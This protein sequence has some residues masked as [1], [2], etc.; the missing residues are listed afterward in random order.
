MRWFLRLT[1]Y[2]REFIKGYG[3]I[4]QPLIELLK[5]NGFQWY[6]AAHKAFD[7]LKSTIVTT[8][9]LALPNFNLEFTIKAD[10]SNSG[11][12]TI[13]SQGG[14][15]VVYFSKALS[16]THQL[17]SVYE[18][19]MLAILI[20]VRKWNAYVVGRHFKIKTNHQSLRFLLDQSLI[21]QHS[22]NGFSK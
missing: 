10:A 14:R 3:S 18:K 15:P 21:H 12:E 1:S 6:K 17:L 19:D 20:A 8:P 4:A 13:L 16:P 7:A 5:N 2:Y 9:V 11:I 22:I